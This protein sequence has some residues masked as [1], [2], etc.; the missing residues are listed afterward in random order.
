MTLWHF[1]NQIIIIIINLWTHGIKLCNTCDMS[2]KDSPNKTD[3]TIT[4]KTTTL[5]TNIMAV[6]KH[7][8]KGVQI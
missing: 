6:S 2:E 3:T 8:P 5:T 1:T 7:I 4:A